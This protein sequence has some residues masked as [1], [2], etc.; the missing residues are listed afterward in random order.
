ME[1]LP[2]VYNP[3]LELVDWSVASDL[4]LGL[5][6]APFASGVFALGVVF[7]A[8]ESGLPDAPFALCSVLLPQKK[9]LMD[10]QKPTLFPSVLTSLFG[11]LFPDVGTDSGLLFEITCALG[12]PGSWQGA[13][14]EAAGFSIGYDSLWY[15][16]LLFGSFSG[17]II[18]CECS[19]WVVLPSFCSSS[20]CKIILEPSGAN[21]SVVLFLDLNSKPPLKK[22]MMIL[23]K[24]N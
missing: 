11:D 8:K 14:G 23:I 9:F 2:V 21:I 19:L 4:G 3:D 10:E 6:R 13:R 5:P 1:R 18:S 16:C 22:L 20:P 24:S 17:P 7:L 15:S 12:D